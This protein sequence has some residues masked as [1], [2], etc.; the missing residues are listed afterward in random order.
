MFFES[1]SNFTLLELDPF[2][3]LDSS[4]IDQ[5]KSRGIDLKE[6]L[7]RSIYPFSLLVFDWVD[8]FG[9]LVHYLLTSYCL[10]LCCPVVALPHGGHP[11]LNIHY[12]KQDSF[13]KSKTLYS[14]IFDLYGYQSEYHRLLLINFEFFPSD[15]L[16]KTGLPSFSSDWIKALNQTILKPF[17]S[18]GLI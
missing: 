9:S 8:P 6:I 15:P 3:F 18:S 12:S 1:F 11:Y 4:H 14:S 7:R 5:F 17:V 2:Y 16:I 13:I 10:K